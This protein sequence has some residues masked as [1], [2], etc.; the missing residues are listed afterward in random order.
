MSAPRQLAL[1]LLQPAA[2]TLENFVVGRNAEALDVLR[3]LA[4]GSAAE[5]IVYL[6]GEAGC[7]RSH[8]AQALAALPG[9]RRFDA[10]DAPD[11]SGLTVVDDVERLSEA[12]Q[13]ALFNRLNAVRARPDASCVATGAAVPAQLS[14][15]ADLRTRLAWGL[16]Y[17]LLPLADAEKADALRLQAAAR[18]LAMTGEVIDTLLTHLPRD[19]RTL[20]AA[21]DALDGYALARKRPLTVPL[22]RQWMTDT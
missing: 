16:V 14:L 15:R 17:R 4:R 5:R 18:G 20:A 8:L 9:A 12:A 19:M 21:L 7:G 2:P 22:V 10:D 3:Q 1:D 11:D 6:W 13:I